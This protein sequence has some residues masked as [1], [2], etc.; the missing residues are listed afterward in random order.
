MKAAPLQLIRYLIS[1]SSC[2]A[3]RDYDP[4]KDSEFRE[5]LFNVNVDLSAGKV[6]EKET[7]A[8]RYWSIEMKLEQKIVP[9]QNFPYAFTATLVGFF[10][11]AEDLPPNISEERMVRV[12]GSSI[13]YGIARE[14]VRHLTSPGPWGELMLPTLSF[15]EPSLDKQPTVRIPLPATIDDKTSQDIRDGLTLF[16]QTVAQK[17]NYGI[18]GDWGR[19]ENQIREALKEFIMMH[20]VTNRPAH[21]QSDDPEHDVF[22][23]EDRASELLRQLGV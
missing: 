8:E 10:T 7:A 19:D 13:L 20:H 2:V 12:N 11:C 16:Y 9:Q 4:Q 22:Y 6:A 1:E 14:V 3:N 17:I 5:D 23:L 18:E 15:Y 21:V